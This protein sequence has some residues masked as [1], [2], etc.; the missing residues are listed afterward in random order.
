MKNKTQDPDIIKAYN[1]H[2]KELR[3]YYTKIASVLSLLLIPA[4]ISLDF[5]MYPNLLMDLFQIRIVCDVITTVILLLTYSRFGYKHIIELG[6]SVIITANLAMSIM[7]FI[8]EG[9][10]SPYYAGLN[11]A[12]LAVGVL[13]PWTFKETLIVCL[14][15]FAMYLAACLLH[16]LL[17]TNK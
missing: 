16:T 10:V 15:T 9:A 6:L 13:M 8:S 4:G 3:L 2:D 14:A 17:M 12:I 5:F 11:L 7:I 1:L